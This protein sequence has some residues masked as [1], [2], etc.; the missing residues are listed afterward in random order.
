MII[1]ERCDFAVKKESIIFV[2]VQFLKKKSQ[3]TKILK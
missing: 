1:H 3:M 2:D